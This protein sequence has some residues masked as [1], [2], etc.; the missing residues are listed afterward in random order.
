MV[1]S[2]GVG[3]CS[4]AVRRRRRCPITGVLLRCRYRSESTRALMRPILLM[5][6]RHGALII[7]CCVL[8]FVSVVRLRLAAVPLERDEGEYAYAGQLILQGTPPYQLAY[9]MKFPG[10]YYAYSVVLA[11]FGQ[12]PSGVRAGLLVVNIATTIVV[13]L[14]GR[15]L[16]GAPGAAAAASTF[17]VLSLDR[18][19]NG[20]FAHATH[21]VLLPA[22][23]GLLVLLRTIESRRAWPAFGAGVLFGVAV[24][25]KQHAIFYVLFAMGMLLVSDVR[26][27]ERDWTRIAR[28]SLAL[29]SGVALPF[30]VLCG[31]L[32][33]QGVL[34]R[35]W[36]WTFDYARA[37]VSERPLADMGEMLRRSWYGVHHVSSSIWALGMVG[38]LA[39]WFARWPLGT[40]MILTVWLVVS[41]L[42]VCPGFYFRPHYFILLLPSVG[43]MTGVLV[44]SVARLFERWTSHAV[45]LTLAAVPCLFALGQYV[46]DER[47]YLFEWSMAQVSRE[48]YKRNPFVE[49]PEIARYIRERTSP[50]DRIAVLGSEPEIFF[51]ANRKSATGY[52]YTYALMEP[53]PFAS[54]MQRE[55]IQEIEAAHPTFL[56]F[57]ERWAWNATPESDK[58]ILEWGDRYVQQ[59]YDLVGLMDLTSLS[60]PVW[61][62]D[63]AVL[64]YKPSSDRL[65]RTYRQKSAD[66]CTVPR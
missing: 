50:D 57:V 39:L 58:T 5:F 35:F 3:T 32:A 64:D 13:F 17:A 49:A 63:R 43:L 44:A 45:A 15:R 61:L 33:A 25:M 9:N 59:C 12:T 16:L 27:P 37:Y 24:L 42:A 53:Q 14:I 26:P 62:W 8:L 55:M 34:G 18:F 31:V 2:A 54:R 7:V 28:R 20:S 19:V 4:L 65:V 6:N 47:P 38:V 29:A 30:A 23:G 41:F 36:F 10:T 11:V 1:T 22:L 46:S 60:S 21:F 66:P 56:V 51:Y 48:V 52:I 40:R